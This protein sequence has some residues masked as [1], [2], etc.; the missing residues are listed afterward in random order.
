MVM[1]ALGIVL[2]SV[3]VVCAFRED[4]SKL[5]SFIAAGFGIADLEALFLFR[6]LERICGLMG[7]MS[8]IILPLNSF[9]TQVGM[10]LMEMNAAALTYQAKLKIWVRP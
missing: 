4:I 1:F 10:P 3:P 6:P 2:I 8:Q 7:D 5:K 9:Q